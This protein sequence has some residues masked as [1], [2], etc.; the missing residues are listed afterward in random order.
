M[1]T[2]GVLEVHNAVFEAN[3]AGDDGGAV[4]FP[5]VAFSFLS[6]AL[7]CDGFCEGWFDSPR[8]LTQPRLKGSLLSSHHV[9][10]SL[11]T[12]SLS[13]S[14]LHVHG[15]SAGG[16]RQCGVQGEHG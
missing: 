12:Y 11:P 16:A 4:S 7:F 9:C 15:R 3:T 2:G 1:Y 13:H 5:F 14:G 6:A 8:E 10:H